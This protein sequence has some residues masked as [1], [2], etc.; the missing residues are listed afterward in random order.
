LD[1]NFNDLY[2]K[3]NKSLSKR[4][5]LNLVTFSKTTIGKYERDEWI[6]SI[7]AAKKLA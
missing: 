1:K 2:E 3:A 7:E 4:A 6:P 5:G